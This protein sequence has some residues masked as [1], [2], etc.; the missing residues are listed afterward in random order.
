MDPIPDVTRFNSIIRILGQNPGNFTL[1]GTNTYLIGTGLSRLLI[2]TGDSNVSAYIDVLE[3]TLKDENAAISDIIITHWHHDHIGG[4]QDI[5]SRKLIDDTCKV[6]KL[7]RT[8]QGENLSKLNIRELTDGQKFSIDGKTLE[9]MHTP[10]HTTDHVCL[11]DDNSKILFSGDTIL[12]EGTAVFEDLY[13]YMTSLEKILS[14]K[15]EVIYPGH[16]NAILSDACAK[17]EFYIRH[18][19]ERERQIVGALE[20]EARPLKV[21]EI[22][23]KIYSETPR[24]LWL[25]AA[26]NVNHHLSKLKREGRVKDLEENHE[27]YWL[28]AAES[29]KL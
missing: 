4:L 19:M 1:Q 8:D 29:N 11:F 3:K 16:G 21:M 14:K 18:R 27:T 25:A 13:D 28:I 24:N 6:W 9:I 12:G 20:A 7:P 2:D 10:G 15:P 5:R 22:V 17:I 23:E 26:S